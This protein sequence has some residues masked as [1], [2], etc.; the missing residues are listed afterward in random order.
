ME[1]FHPDFLTTLNITHALISSVQY[2]IQTMNN[3]RRTESSE[4]CNCYKKLLQFTINML[5]KCCETR[6]LVTDGI[7]WQDTFYTSKCYTLK[8][9]NYKEYMCRTKYNVQNIEK[10]PME[11]YPEKL[12]RNFWSVTR[13]LQ[14]QV[15][16]EGIKFL[17]HLTICDPDFIIQ[18]PD[19]E[20]SFH[21]FVRNII[22]F[23]D[24]ILR[25]NERKYYTFGIV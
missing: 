2:I 7:E 25:E 11:I 22:F 3:L 8:R 16:K 24:L 5:R 23:D 14:H 17:C 4:L 18:L 19:I 10:R 13:R 20:D 6:L 21:L 12:D 9:V 1:H 15:L